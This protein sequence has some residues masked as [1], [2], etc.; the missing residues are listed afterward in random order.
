VG[1]LGPHGR[2]FGQLEY[3][4]PP[5]GRADSGFLDEITFEEFL[6]RA[7][8][9]HDDHQRLTL[10]EHV[11][12]PAADAYRTRVAAG[13]RYAGLTITTQAQADNALANPS[14]N[15]HHGA[16][17]TCVYKPQSAACRDENDNHGGGPAWSRCRLSCRNV[18]RTDRDITEL[19]RHVH[20]LTADLAAPGLPGT[21]PAT[22]PA[23]PPRT[24]TGHRRT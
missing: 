3:L 4:T 20:D 11:S 21:P 10:G 2:V 17:L 12:G 8:T 15:I 1:E 23:A 7:E 18:A 9:L 24:R 19:R 13:G 5:V 6:L 22:P 14:L 16:L